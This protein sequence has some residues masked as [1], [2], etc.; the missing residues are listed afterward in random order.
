MRLFPHY[1]KVVCDVG[2]FYYLNNNGF[3]VLFIKKSKIV[4]MF[5]TFE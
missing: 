4:Y 3:I 1:E 5:I 2:D